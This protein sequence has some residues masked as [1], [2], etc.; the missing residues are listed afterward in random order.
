[1]AFIELRAADGVTEAALRAWLVTRL[2][3]YKRP[4]RFVFMETLP[5]APS[6]KVLKSRL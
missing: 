6:G 3:P 4:A 5:A 1:V 2:A